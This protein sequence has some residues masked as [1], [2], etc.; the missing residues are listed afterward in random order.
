M[1]VDPRFRQMGQTARRRRRKSAALRSGVAGLAVV[2]LGGVI[3]WQFAPRIENLWTQLTGADQMTQ[4]EAEFDIAPVTPGDTFTDIPGDPMIIP[5]M[6]QGAVAPA[7]PS[8][9]PPR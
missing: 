1:Q 6:D 2:A 7:R 4:V 8:W 3:W 5:R 9:P